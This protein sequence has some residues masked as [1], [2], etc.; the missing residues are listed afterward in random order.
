MTLPQ[1]L[2]FTPGPTK[3]ALYCPENPSSSVAFLVVHR[4]ANYLAHPV[5]LEMP[6]RG[7]TVLAMN[8]RYDN[9]E[10]AVIFE[11]IA[12]DI[13]QG[14]SYL[15][16]L[17]GIER[18]VLVGHS[19]G[20]PSVSFYQAVA[21]NGATYAQGPHKLTQGGA[22]LENLPRADG[23]VFLDAHP[24][25]GVNILRCL[26]PA[27][28]NEDKPFDLDPSLDPFLPENGFNPEGDSTY[29]DAFLTRY[30][31]AQ[32]RRMNALIARAEHLR[33]EMEMGRRAPA[34][35]DVFTVYRARARLSDISTSVAGGTERPQKLIR[36]D[37]HIEASRPVCTVRVPTPRNA[38][39]DKGFSGTLQRTVRSFLSSNAIRSTDSVE[40]I[41]WSSSN[42]S[43]IAAVREI[44]VPVLVLAMQAHYFIRDGE[45]IFDN[46]ASADKDFAI[47]EGAAHWLK[48]CPEASARMGRDYG[49]ARRN[50]FDYVDA[51]VRARF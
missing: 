48:G 40:K 35:D 22:A 6:P 49:N 46:A 26:N 44:S 8:P 14:V 27:V 50:L 33:G 13:A 10:P 23:V 39:V 15:R 25:N 28:T 32:S 31:V 18:V 16:A 17:P 38:A 34:D 4:T 19:G 2:Q 43:T 42:N 30:F 24:G 37:G 9:N 5:A 41:D 36:N 20:G 11:D 47:V 12:L 1:Y 51:W 21:E 3:G 29:S 45:M 7:H